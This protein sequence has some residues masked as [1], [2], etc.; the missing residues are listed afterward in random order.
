MASEC[1]ACRLTA[2]DE[3]L[4]GGRIHATEHWLVEHCIGP[5]GTGTLIVK[6]FRHCLPRRGP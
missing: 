3:P 4:P 6:P 2:G 1:L 5:L